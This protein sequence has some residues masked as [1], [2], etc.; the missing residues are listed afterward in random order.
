MN[1]ALTCIIFT[2]D[3][4]LKS[5]L[6]KFTEERPG[7]HLV[8]QYSDTDENVDLKQIERA[9]ILIFDMHPQSLPLYSKLCE[10][11]TGLACICVS[12]NI[13]F[14][15]DAIETGAS[16]FLLKP[17][18]LSDLHKAVTKVTSKIEKSN[19][20]WPTDNDH[21]FI[22]SGGKGKL[23]R[24]DFD[25]IL[26]IEAVD[27]YLHIQTLESKYV[28]NLSLAEI[29][30]MLPEKGFVRVHKSFVVR[31]EM[32]RE[33]ASNKIQLKEQYVIPIGDVYKEQF[34]QK[35]QIRKSK[36]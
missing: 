18:D 6:K 8:G 10:R 4:L 25:D 15:L 23:V 28:T 12:D 3:E 31:L 34:L 5:F 33:I 24:L 9:D 36:T 22:N 32:I 17:I 14:A 26:F 13:K 16:S 27:H 30:N 19:M 21:I 35:L 7:L 2:E 29:L 11:A 20:V 1:S